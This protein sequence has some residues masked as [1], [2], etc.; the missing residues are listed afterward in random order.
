MNVH[1]N[2]S[3]INKNHRSSES[4]PAFMILMCPRPTSNQKSTRGKSLLLLLFTISTMSQRSLGL[5][6]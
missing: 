3:N 2:A 6:E 1:I 5:I 4:F